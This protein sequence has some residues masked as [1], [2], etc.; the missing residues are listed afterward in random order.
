MRDLLRATADLAADHIE[1]RNERPI[2]PDA[3]AADILAAIDEP[4]PAGP[5]APLTVIEDLARAAEPG[6]LAIDSPRFYGWVCGGSL[7]VAL[8]AD[9][10][11]SAWDQNAGGERIAPGT[12][13]IEAVAGRWLVDLFGLPGDTSLG[14]VTGCQMAHVTALAA[15]RYRVLERAGWD[16]GRDG[17]TGAPRIRVIAGEE[18]HITIDRALRLLGIGTA[19]IEPVP[20][21]AVGAMRADALADALRGLDGPAIVCAQVGNVNTGAI[22]PIAEIC[23]AAHA[24]GAW[25]HV[26]GAFG[27][28]AA[29]S[30]RR[31][32]LVAG[33]DR[34]DSWATDAHKWLNV[35]YDC[36]M[37]LVADADALRVAMTIFS[38]VIADGA[39][40]GYVRDALDSSPEF[41]R[42]ARG[43]PAY[44]ALRSLGRSGVED[45][46][47]RLC[48]CAERFAERLAAEPG[49]E[50]LAQGL[51]QVL[52]R[53]GDDDA[54]TEDVLER[55]RQEGT[56]FMSGTEWRGLHAMRISV[57]N[58]QTTF[59][60]VDRSVDAL[61]AAMKVSILPSGPLA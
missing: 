53:F 24:V 47:D 42:R 25:V 34:A 45:L 50:V 61:L 8:G 1:P 58:W 21:D 27:L 30:P 56:V 44:A 19:T 54:V 60:E 16:V 59:D 7:P 14:F 37:A 32:G 43:V 52:V 51:N 15:A 22:D 33:L 5:T 48:D 20:S 31:R 26:D 6:L 41:S 35:P 57:S 36:G 10:L 49:V 46:V 2:R 39:G 29:A 13:A 12:S 23:E 11:V 17:L 55:S 40:A 28:W 38:P 4:L 9:W 18:R 3:S